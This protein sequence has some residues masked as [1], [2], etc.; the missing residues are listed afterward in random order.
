MPRTWHHDTPNSCH[1]TITQQVIHPLPLQRRGSNWGIF[2]LLEALP[3]LVWKGIAKAIPKVFTRWCFPPAKVQPH[4]VNLQF[5]TKQS[6]C[7]LSTLSSGLSFC[8]EPIQLL[9]QGDP[10]PLTLVIAT[11]QWWLQLAYS[12]C[13]RQSK[14]VKSTSPTTILLSRMG[15]W[16]ED[17]L[18]IISLSSNTHPLRNEQIQIEGKT[19][20][21][22]K[23]S[24]LVNGAWKTKR[25]WEQE[26]HWSKVKNWN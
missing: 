1:F 19:T 10:D 3:E 18:F 26:Q 15:G 23:L 6:S 8:P 16:K 9:S 4:W 17:P 24:L 13:C 20:G 2:S 25:R 11:K 12:Y 21:T 14:V 7:N 5:K 22:R